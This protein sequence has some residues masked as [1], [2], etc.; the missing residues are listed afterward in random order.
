[1]TTLIAVGEAAAAVVGIGGASAV[2]VKGVRILRKVGHFFDQWF[3]NSDVRSPGVVDRLVALET[4]TVEAKS[5]AERA[6]TV[7]E[8]VAADAT[9]GREH[10]ASLITAHDGDA[11]KWLADGQAW[12]HR[13]DARLDAL[14]ATVNPDPQLK[15]PAG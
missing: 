13:I 2:V 1:M 12:G 14:E 7:A 6:V 11:A 8:T 10:L 9:S 5:A 15:P 4:A 3:G